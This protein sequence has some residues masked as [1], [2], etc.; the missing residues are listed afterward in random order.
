[1]EETIIRNVTRDDNIVKFII[2]NVE[3][4]PGKAY[5]IFSV[6]AKN[7]ICIDI[8]LQV[9]GEN[10]TKNIS[11]TTSGEYFEKTLDVLQNQ[12]S[13]AYNLE[14]TKSVSKISIIGAGMMNQPGIAAMVFETMCDLNIEIQMASTSEMNISIIIDEA[15]SPKAL[16][17]LREKMCS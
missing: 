1:V 14:F 10:N 2:K 13:N 17:A 8:I 12:L 11:F 3:D 15:D 6:L 4:V 9:S 16:R 7:D 5:N